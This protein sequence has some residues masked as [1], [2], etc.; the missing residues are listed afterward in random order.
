MGVNL[1]NM[2][3]ED[4]AIVEN[5][6]LAIYRSGY[7]TGYNRAKGEAPFSALRGLMWAAAGMAVAFI[8]MGLT[9]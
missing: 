6:I 7:A 2:S 4:R 8:A 9:P 3:D 1:E 5:G